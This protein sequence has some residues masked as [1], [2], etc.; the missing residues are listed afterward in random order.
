MWYVDE[1]VAKILTD[2]RRRLFVEQ[3][4]C[5]VQGSFCS[6]RTASGLLGW[7]SRRGGCLLAS[8][9]RQ[10]TMWGRRL[11]RYGAPQPSLR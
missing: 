1:H 7:L 3:M 5:P 2:R 9:G 4:G 8:I 10:L 6:S 11:E